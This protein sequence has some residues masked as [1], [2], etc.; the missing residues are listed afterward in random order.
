MD[1]GKCKCPNGD[2]A[3][4]GQWGNLLKRRIQALYWSWNLPDATWRIKLPQ[5]L[6]GGIKR[7]Q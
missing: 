1:N 5:K 3:A 4:F 6:Q 7:V 2:V